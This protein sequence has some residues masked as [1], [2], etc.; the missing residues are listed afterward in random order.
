LKKLS[1][2]NEE[3]KPQMVDVGAKNKSN[4]IAHAQSI[5][6]FPKDLADRFKDGDIKTKKGP[7][8]STAIIAGVMAAKKTH[9]LIPFCHRLCV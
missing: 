7:V 6:I 8:F 5:V 4:R 9:E 3:N 2:I 1:H